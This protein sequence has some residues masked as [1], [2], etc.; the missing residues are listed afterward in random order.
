MAAAAP[1]PAPGA[2]GPA[3][4]LQPAGFPVSVKSARAQ[5]GGLP[6]DLIASKYEDALLLVVSQIGAF[7]TVIRAK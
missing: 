5:V 4:P 3:P 7:G 6:T 2:G 1:P